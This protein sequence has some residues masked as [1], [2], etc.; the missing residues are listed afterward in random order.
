[1]A[2]YNFVKMN[3]HVK[4]ISVAVLAIA[5]A[6]LTGI[7]AYQQ[8]SRFEIGVGVTLVV[9]FAILHAHLAQLARDQS[10]RLTSRGF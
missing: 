8:T 1:M 4:R 5:F 7:V 3:K 6:I 10:A 2:W 9:G